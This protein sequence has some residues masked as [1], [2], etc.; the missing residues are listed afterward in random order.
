VR[1]YP[2]FIHQARKTARGGIVI[3]QKETQRTEMVGGKYV[4][5]GIYCL[6]HKT[7][8]VGDDLIWQSL[9]FCCSGILIDAKIA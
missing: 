4:D 8:S 9:K 7:M 3:F 1:N 2:D 5:N 6:K